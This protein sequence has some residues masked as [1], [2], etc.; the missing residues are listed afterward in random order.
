MEIESRQMN[1]PVNHPECIWKT[2][3]DFPLYEISINGEVRHKV[4]KIIRKPYVGKRGYPI[5]TMYNNGKLYVRTIHRL[6][7]KAF[8]PNP[9]NLPTINHIDGN[10]LNYSISNLEWCSYRDNIIHA[11]RTGLHKSDGDKPVSAYKDGIKIASYKSISE[12]SRQTGISRSSI[13]FVARGI[14]KYKTA[15]GYYWRY[16]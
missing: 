8:I 10:K 3:E 7:G 16:E 11:R 15:G 2:I 13:G 1:D 6:I 9:H 5:V 4:N 14:P 12:A